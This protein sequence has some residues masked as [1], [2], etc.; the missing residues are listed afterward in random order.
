MSQKKVQ[1]QKTLGQKTDVRL[2]IEPEI[3]ALACANA[4]ARHVHCECF[5]ISYGKFA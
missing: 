1:T 4:S 5:E 3:A 2:M